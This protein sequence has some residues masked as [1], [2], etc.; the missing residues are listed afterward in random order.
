MK[1]PLDVNR[2]LA[3]L[4]TKG[5]SNIE[6]L[7]VGLKWFNNGD[8]IMEQNQKQ[9][10]MLGMPQSLEIMGNIK[11]LWNVENGTRK[12]RYVKEFGKISV[13]LFLSWNI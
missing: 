1:T 6:P 10:P 12:Y 13:I 2:L 8:S 7:L 9:L 5:W 4:A 11:K 3:A